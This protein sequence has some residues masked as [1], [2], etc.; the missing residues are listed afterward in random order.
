MSV[1]KRD[2]SGLFGHHQNGCN[3]GSVSILDGNQ[4]ALRVPELPEVSAEIS[5]FDPE[6]QWF[7]QGPIA[8]VK[9]LWYGNVRNETGWDRSSNFQAKTIESS[10]SQPHLTHGSIE[11]ATVNVWHT[12]NKL[13]INGS[14]DFE[15]NSDSVSHWDWNLLTKWV[16]SSIN[17]E[18]M[19]SFLFVHRVKNQSSPNPLSDSEHFITVKFRIHAS[20]TKLN[21]T[22]TSDLT[23]VTGK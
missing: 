19:T 6:C 22:E 3:V 23:A 14:G 20:I 2:F 11:F 7:G 4:N 5:R 17:S 9:Q 1:C 10:V 18:S 21:R 16:C 15:S 8:K 13:V 12:L